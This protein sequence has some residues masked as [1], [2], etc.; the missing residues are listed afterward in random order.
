MWTKFNF[1]NT[2]ISNNYYAV[3]EIRAVAASNYSFSSK[4]NTKTYG[5]IYNNIFYPNDPS[6]NL[7]THENNTNRNG[8]FKMTVFLQAWTSYL[9]LVTTF[10]RNVTGNLSIAVSGPTKVSIR[11]FRK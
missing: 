11:D 7:L 8:Q 10:T 1:N 9:L 5:Y 3:F 6:V 2:F 4:S